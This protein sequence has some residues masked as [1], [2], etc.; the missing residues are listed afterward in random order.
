MKTVTMMMNNPWL[1][2]DRLSRIRVKETIKY[3]AFW[4]VDA[5]NKYGLMM[6]CDEDFIQPI[7]EIKLNGIQIQLDQSSSPNKLILLLKESKDWEIFLILCN[8]LINVMKEHNENIIVNVMK[9][10]ERWQKLLRKSSFKIMSKEEQMGLY[11]EL[12][13]LRDYI[14]PAYGYSVGI[15]GWVGALGDKQDF[16]L[17]N[18]AIE[19]KS[20]RMTSGNRVWISSKEQ[21][22]SEKNPLYLFSCALNEAGSGETIADLVKSIKEKIEN[23]SLSNE[24]TEKVEEYG[25]FPEIPQE[26]LSKFLL[27]QVIGYE[28]RDGF[29]KIASEHVSHLIPNIKY[30]IDLSGC[31]NFKV[32]ITDILI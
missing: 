16:L 1:Q 21:L 26:S 24:F 8:D 25:Y 7:R 31:T 23:E 14:I 6:Q 17:K 20:F 28:V 13:I 5:F 15:H 29:P 9:R 18:F 2:L 19:V 32:N 27:E 4:I 30:N 22:N 11:S 12:K 10:V 3:N